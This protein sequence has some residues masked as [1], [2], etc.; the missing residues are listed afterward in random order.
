MRRSCWVLHLPLYCSRRSPARPCCG[1]ALQWVVPISDE[2][3]EEEAW[4]GIPDEERGCCLVCRCP[5]L[6]DLYLC[7]PGNW[8]PGPLPPETV[9]FG[10]HA[11]VV[12]NPDEEWGGGL[13]PRWNWYALLVPVSHAPASC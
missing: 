9:F 7:P 11:G 1:S 2:E 3:E 13:V 6:V 8:A 4:G 10:G 5:W 12:A